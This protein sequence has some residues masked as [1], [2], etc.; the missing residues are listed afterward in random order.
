MRSVRARRA[1][2]LDA[3]KSVVV[4]HAAFDDVEAALDA[5]AVVVHAHHF[6]AA[7]VPV[8]LAQINSTIGVAVEIEKPAFHPDTPKVCNSSRQCR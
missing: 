8:V 3:F 6:D 5:D 2:E 1:S 4:R 7:D